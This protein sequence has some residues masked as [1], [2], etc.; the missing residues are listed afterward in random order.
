MSNGF[1][2]YL[3]RLNNLREQNR[4]L[5]QICVDLAAALSAIMECLPDD[6]KE[7]PQ[8]RR[9]MEVCINAARSLESKNESHP[10]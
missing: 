4:L 8:V 9:S 2:D 5:R 6:L 1:D 3:S 10:D 7:L